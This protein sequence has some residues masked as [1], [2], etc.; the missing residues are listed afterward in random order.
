MK[1]SVYSYDNYKKFFNDWV[2][3]QPRQGHGEYRRVALALGVSTTMISQIFKGDKQ[4]SMESAC[5]LCEYL[6]LEEE[7]G[8]FLLLLVEFERAGSMKLSKQLKRQIQ[9]LQAKNLTLENRI[10]SDLE[11]SDESK[12]QFYS[13]WCYT[14]VGLL[15]DLPEFNDAKTIAQRLELPVLFVQKILDFLIENNLCVL[16][17]G[18]LKMGPAKTH[19]GSSS[20]LVNQHHRNWRQLAVNKM[21]VSENKNLFFTGPMA[22]SQDV[23]NQIRKDLPNFIE[24]VLRK[25]HPSPSEVVRCLNIDWFEY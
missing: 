1:M 8:D 19:V 18:N 2:E 24:E 20:N 22:L 14:G 6:N 5:E 7:E 16:E 15:I 12:A 17:N 21:I 10:R 3:C 4:L 25:V 11:L 9:A 13:S 23:A